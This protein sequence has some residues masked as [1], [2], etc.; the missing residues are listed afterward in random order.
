MA[1]IAVSVAMLTT[2]PTMAPPIA[3]R[4]VPIAGAITLPS[5]APIFAPAA[6][7]AREPATPTTR[8]CPTA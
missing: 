3:P 5:A 1:L 4:A 7:A 8:P 2:V 6:V